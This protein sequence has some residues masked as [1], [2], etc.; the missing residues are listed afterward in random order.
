MDFNK[1]DFKQTLEKDCPELFTKLNSN[2]I[3][4][5]YKYLLNK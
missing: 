2:F 4:R 3:L 5:I 1:K